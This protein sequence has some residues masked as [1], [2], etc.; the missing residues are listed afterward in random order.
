MN[1]SGAP[2]FLNHPKIRTVGSIEADVRARKKEEQ[3]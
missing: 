1:P 3:S 2:A